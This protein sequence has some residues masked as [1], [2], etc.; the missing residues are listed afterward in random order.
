MFA[1]L[2]AFVSLACL[3]SL[4]ER[5]LSTNPFLKKKKEPCVKTMHLKIVILALAT[6]TALRRY[7]NGEH[8][9]ISVSLGSSISWP[10]ES[11]MK[12]VVIVLKKRGRRWQYYRNVEKTRQ[13]KENEWG[14]EN[15]SSVVN[16]IGEFELK[17]TVVWHFGCPLPL[18][19]IKMEEAVIDLFN[20]WMTPSSRRK[21]P[22]LG[23][24][25]FKLRGR[26][27]CKHLWCTDWL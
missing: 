15:K 5:V 19:S 22:P 1:S 10:T 14:I 16:G 8:V 18:N 21:N 26:S 12:L 2:P 4:H 24:S 6:F 17:M 27:K 3:S 7:G 23:F 9:H 11:A 25:T 13:S 20:R